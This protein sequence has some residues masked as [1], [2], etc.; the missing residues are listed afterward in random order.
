[1]WIVESAMYLVESTLNVAFDER[2]CI[3]QKVLSKKYIAVCTWRQKYFKGLFFI[4]FNW[5]MAF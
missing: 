4:F 2:K 5:D 1:M 3:L